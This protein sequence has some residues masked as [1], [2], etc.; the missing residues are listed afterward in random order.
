MAGVAKLP[1]H[2]V[3]C[4]AP[5]ADSGGDEQL[6]FEID[7]N[8]KG[9]VLKIGSLSRSLVSSLPDRAIDLIEIAAF[10]YAID[11]SVSRGGLRDQNMAAKWYRKFRIDLPVR[12]LAL[13]SDSEVKRDL[14]ETLMFLSGDRF[15]FTFTQLGEEAREPDRF[16]DFGKEGSWSPDT[17]M[18]FSGGL[19]SYAG[20]LEE[21][22]DRKYKVALISHF[23]STK[24]APIQNSLVNDMAESLGLTC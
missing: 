23:S 19:D 6:R 8:V 15:E 10:V 18:L 9:V 13:W 16:F 1:E 12:E 2:R 24:I 5:V 17:V 7:G 20:A 4:F 22:I 14:E 11:A 21:I 3:R